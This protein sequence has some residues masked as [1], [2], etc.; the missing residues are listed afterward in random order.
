[1][2][3]CTESHSTEVKVAVLQCK[4]NIP[5]QVLNTK[6][7]VVELLKYCQQS[8]LEVSKVKSVITHGMSCY[9][10]VYYIIIP[11]TLTCEHHFNV[12]AAHD[13]ADLAHVL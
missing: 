11:D 8:V 12:L 10:T 3:E 4:K 2:F 5:L 9:H 13:G 1:M 7:H 6:C